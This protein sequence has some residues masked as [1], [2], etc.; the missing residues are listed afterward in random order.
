MAGFMA[1][2]SMNHVFKGSDHLKYMSYDE[3]SLHKGGFLMLV[4]G[5]RIG[6]YLTIQIPLTPE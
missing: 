2:S 3:K 6:Q 4:A 5:A 1:S